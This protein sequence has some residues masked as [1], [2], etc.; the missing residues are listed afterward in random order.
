MASGDPE[1]SRQLLEWL[2]PLTMVALPLVV[3]W[4]LALWLLL[5]NSAPEER[6]VRIARQ[7]GEP[8]PEVKMGSVRLVGAD[9]H[10]EAVLGPLEPCM[11]RL[12]P[13]R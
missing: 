5:V 13:G 9:D 4:L 7:P 3:F 6:R 1:R 8:A 10:I 2:T 12:G 11:L